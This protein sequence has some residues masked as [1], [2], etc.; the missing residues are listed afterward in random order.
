[1]NADGWSGEL[2]H[3]VFLLGS[4]TGIFTLVQG[5]WIS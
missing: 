4:K 5:E 3:P 2:N 1:M